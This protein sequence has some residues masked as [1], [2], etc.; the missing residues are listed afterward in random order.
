MIQ[1]GEDMGDKKKKI[2]IDG[3]TYKKALEAAVGSIQPSE[4]MLEA[5][6]E[7][8]QLDIVE[9]AT[10]YFKESEQMELINDELRKKGHTETFEDLVK[11][12]DPSLYNIIMDF[13]KTITA[14]ADP[15]SKVTEKEIEKVADVFNVNNIKPKGLNFPVDKVNH[16]IWTLAE[17]QGKMPGQI[18]IT[19]FNPSDLLPIGVEKEG[20][21]RNIYYGVD[22]SPKEKN[23]VEQISIGKKL[24]AFDRRV[25]D[26]IGTLY[27]AGNDIVSL[28]QISITMGGSDKPSSR[29]LD[30]IANS[31]DKM[32]AAQ[33]VLDQSEDY[34]PYIKHE[35]RY[36]GSVVASE[37]VDA[38]INGVFAQNAVHIFREPFLM[39]FARDR[40]QITTI[41]R[42]VIETDKR[43]TEN[44]L[45]IESYLL[46]RISRMKH[47]KTKSI[48]KILYSNMFKVTNITGKQQQRALPTVEDYLKHY[49][50]VGWIKGYKL[51]PDGVEIGL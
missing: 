49:K 37:Y 4:E 17:K 26:A 32:R 39:T 19:N 36:K 43:K 27:N 18:T 33:I 7:E 5:L 48:K 46:E 40:E 1:Q 42:E 13:L 44:N 2:K 30:K 21:E 31:I 50:K 14:D 45:A 15:D 47:N 41:P 34:A 24:T 8:I 3:E 35:K 51:V 25:H 9:I 38:K 6:V 23:G 10:R 29:M 16:R 22:F 28:T 11:A 12:N 20:K